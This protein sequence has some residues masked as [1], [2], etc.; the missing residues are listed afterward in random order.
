MY[1]IRQYLIFF[2][3]VMLFCFSCGACWAA[4]TPLL[5]VIYIPEQANDIIRA[6]KHHNNQKNSQGDV[7]VDVDVDSYI[8]VCWDFL[9]M[10][11]DM[12]VLGDCKK[13]GVWVY[14]DNHNTG[15]NIDFSEGI[16]EIVCIDF[17]KHHGEK[18]NVFLEQYGDQK[19]RKELNE[20]LEAGFYPA[21]LVM[22]S[23]KNISFYDSTCVQKK[24]AGEP[25]KRV[26]YQ[27]DIKKLIT[28]YSIGYS[29]QSVLDLYGDEG[30]CPDQV[31]NEIVRITGTEMKKIGDYFDDSDSQ[32]LQSSL[33]D[34]TVCEV[35]SLF[36]QRFM[37]ME[38]IKNNMKPHGWDWKQAK[39]FFRQ[40]CSGDT[41]KNSGMCSSMTLGSRHEFDDMFKEKE[42]HKLV[43]LSEA[44]LEVEQFYKELPQLSTD[45]LKDKLRS[46]RYISEGHLDYFPECLRKRYPPMAFISGRSLEGRVFKCKRSL[47]GSCFDPVI[48]KV[49]KPGFF[50]KE[51]LNGAKGQYQLIEERILPDFFADV[52]EQG[53]ALFDDVRCYYQVMEFLPFSMND[54]FDKENIDDRIVRFLLSRLC[55]Y[56]C[57]MQ[58]ER[59]A[60]R[61]IKP[62]NLMLSA[63]GELKIVDFGGIVQYESIG[64]YRDGFKGTVGFN[65]YLSTREKL[66]DEYDPFHHDR[67]SVGMVVICLL[68]GGMPYENI[69]STM[70]GSWKEE[71]KCVQ[72]LTEL[73]NWGRQVGKNKISP[74]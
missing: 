9:L 32:F 35:R 52:I 28:L 22:D 56:L 20:S 69:V 67:F 15:V 55:F 63:Q 61:D 46:Q 59:V 38:N 26:C 10:K 41:F 3:S 49:N 19:V 1:S 57:C 21:C 29:A 18:G 50:P 12:P 47:S 40:Q 71:A 66:D 24:N 7:D 70:N 8:Q 45:K 4:K 43:S 51:I 53:Y 16:G 30:V 65:P 48:V 27:R 17:Y 54:F 14:Y 73:F 36:H 39:K 23:H 5:R 72:F 34:N 44:T 62:D 25:D 13:E 2:I 58:R 31:F 37:R 64:N 42:L 68:F 74:W 60:H 6:M 11:F 33:T